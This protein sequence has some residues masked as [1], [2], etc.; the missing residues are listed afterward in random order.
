MPSRWLRASSVPGSLIQMDE[1]SAADE[2]RS[3]QMDERIRPMS[4]AN[5]AAASTYEEW[6]AGAVTEHL[7]KAAEQGYVNPSTASAMATA[8]RKIMQALHRDD[9]DDQSLR[10]LD[11]DDT[12]KRFENLAQFKIETMHTYEKRF[13][14]ALESYELWLRDKKQWAQEM[15]SQPRRRRSTKSETTSTSTDSTPSKTSG[16][17]PESASEQTSASAPDRASVSPS[18]ELLDY[19][20][21]LRPGVYAYLRLPPDL[22][23]TDAQRLAAFIGALVME[24]MPELGTGDAEADR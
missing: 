1:M 4:D 2:G 12:F 20:F 19:Q 24:P 11:L 15:N 21:P 22:R 17:Q 14:K 3:A 5:G 10:D 7:D 6:A 18:E 13:V 23:K 9:W 8:V 16:L